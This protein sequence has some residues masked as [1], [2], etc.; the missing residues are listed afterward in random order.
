M[1][2]D[3]IAREIMK[4]EEILGIQIRKEEIKLSLFE[5]DVILN[6]YSP[7]NATKMLGCHKL[8][9]KVA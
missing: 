1:L 3:F 4:V 5:D 6:I 2:L 9:P 8:S 7:K